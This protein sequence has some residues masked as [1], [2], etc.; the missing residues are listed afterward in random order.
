MRILAIDVFEQMLVSICLHT[1]TQHKQR[2]NVL[3]RRTMNIYG[4]NAMFRMTNDHSTNKNQNISKKFPIDI[5][6]EVFFLLSVSGI[7]KKSQSLI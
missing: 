1:N 2:T 3:S 6:D 7:K 4:V 5:C